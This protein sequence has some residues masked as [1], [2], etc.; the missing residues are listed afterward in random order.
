[1]FKICV[2]FVVLC[3][4]FS[5]PVFSENVQLNEI[6]TLEQNLGIEP[7]NSAI[8]PR[9]DAI[10]NMLFGYTVD[11]T[12]PNRIINIKNSLGVAD[13]SKPFLSLPYNTTVGDYYSESCKLKMAKW[14]KSPVTV[15]VNNV[16]AKYK[17]T[18][19]TSV[20]KWKSFFP[21]EISDNSNSDITFQWV[22]SIPKS[23]RYESPLGQAVMS[24]KGGIPKCNILVC[25]QKS[26]LSG[27]LEEILLHEIGH[28]LGLGHSPNAQDIM[29]PKVQS[30]KGRI[31][32]LTIIFVGYIP[33]ILPTGF[34]QSTPGKTII[35]Q[36]D[37][38]TLIRIYSD[39]GIPQIYPVNYVSSS[40][41][42]F[43]KN[44]KNNSAPLPQDPEQNN[45]YIKQDINYYLNLAN[46]YFNKQ[47][48]SSAIEY[49]KKVL[50][51]NPNY[52]AANENLGAC[53]FRINK[54]DS[55]LV[56]LNKAISVNPNESNAYVTVA[57]VYVNTGKYDLAESNCKKAIGLNPNSSNAYNNLGLVYW[58]KG[59]HKQALECFSRSLSLDPNNRAARQN[60]DNLKKI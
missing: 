3:C 11:D 13:T 54:Y 32:R 20:N 16:P 8:V 7:I 31:N 40:R 53:Y 37:V 14:T 12:I 42:N 33:I 21:L 26:Y 10:E 45:T 30:K 4:F 38:N 1:M 57:A 39:N 2:F 58:N 25:K 28:A 24:F 36:R 19:L 47:N 41:D 56:Y 23:S 6:S 43:N 50:S 46:D 60:I 59:L 27:A 15:Y 29:Y 17:N 52:V 5:Q 22:N 9:I 35:T 55:A 51:I 49:Y 48:Y 18:V 44:A 34:Q